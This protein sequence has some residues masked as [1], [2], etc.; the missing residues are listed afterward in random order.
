MHMKTGSAFRLLLSVMMISAVVQL[1]SQITITTGDMPS[2]GDTIRK[3]TNISTLGV[4]YT[5]TGENYTWDFSEM[6]PLTQT[7]DTFASVSTVPFAYQLVFIPGLVANLAQK[8]PEI[9]TIPE[10]Q[11]TD[12]YR[13][14]KNS[15]ASYDDVGIAVTLNGLPIPLKFDNPDVLYDFPVAW[16]N[17]DSS[18]SGV[19]FGISGLGYLS[20]DRKRVNTVDGWGTL[21]SPYGTFEV[22]RLKSQVFETDSVYIDSIGF[23]T[24]IERV[25]TEYKWLAGGFGEPLLQVYEEGPLF[26]VAYIDSVRNPITGIHPSGI[27]ARS[28]RVLPNPCSGPAEVQFALDNSA[29][30]IIGIYSLTGQYLAE[31]LR[32]HLPAGAHSAGFDTRK[33]GLTP[34]VYFVKIQAGHSTQVEKIVVR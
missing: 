32:K 24:Q 33:A 16:G 8:F 29:E 34:G 23:G 17:V 7:V 31:I 25:Y 14:F 9:D 22:L 10:L 19:E 18:F 20:I 21:K 12:P 2:A 13:F 28:F 26:S 3:S 4:D 5:A 15:S 1:R 11:L 27:A 6:F 30:I